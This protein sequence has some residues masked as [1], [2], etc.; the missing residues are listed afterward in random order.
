MISIY[1]NQTLLSTACLVSIY[2]E[3]QSLWIDVLSIYY[4]FSNI[5]LGLIPFLCEAALN[6]LISYFLAYLALFSNETL[7]VSGASRREASLTEEAI[8]VLI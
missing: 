6:L 5:L 2:P 7:R 3:F 1:V 8:A 4:D